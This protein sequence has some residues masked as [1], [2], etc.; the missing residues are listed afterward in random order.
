MI[1]TFFTLTGEML[2]PSPS[3]DAPDTTIQIINADEVP[4]K[5]VTT[6]LSP[7][8]SLYREK[9]TTPFLYC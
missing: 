1:D 6:I 7:F 8:L 2:F 4:T 3:T 9:I 5:K